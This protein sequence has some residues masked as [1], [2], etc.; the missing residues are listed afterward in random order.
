MFTPRLF[1]VRIWQQPLPR[2]GTAFRASVRAP[3]EEA[4][5]LF[6]R[7]DSLVRFFEQQSLP[8]EVAESTTSARKRTPLER[9]P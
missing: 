6:T 9:T 2:G 4:A 8:Q 3:T 1:L 7:A 5:R